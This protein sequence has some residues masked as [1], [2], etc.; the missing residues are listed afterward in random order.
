MESNTPE[1]I[2]TQETTT[3]LNGESAGMIT[4]NSTTLKSSPAD[5][6]VQEYLS[7]GSK[8]LSQIFDYLKEF[9]D[10]NQKSLINLLLIFL[11]IIAVKVTLAIISAINDIPL[12]A[13][14]FELVGLGYT[15]WFVYRYLLTNSSRQELGQEFQALKNQ[16]M[17][18]E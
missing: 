13:P 17:G 10:S 5:N 12:L 15:G 8:F 1:V 9:I 7:I 16:V 11:G 14:T 18:Q 3:S 2:E 4:P 6:A